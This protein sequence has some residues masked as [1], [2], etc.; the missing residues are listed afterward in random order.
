MMGTLTC[1]HGAG[2]AL[3]LQQQTPAV[4]REPLSTEQDPEVPGDSPCGKPCA[5]GALY[6]ISGIGYWILEAAQGRGTGTVQNTRSERTRMR[7]FEHQPA[8]GLQS[9][10]PNGKD[11]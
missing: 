5:C 8:Y 3:Y 1:E 11:G 10:A 6:R 2:R 7:A 9:M 4:P